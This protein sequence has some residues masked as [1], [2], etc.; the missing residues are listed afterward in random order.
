MKN[1]ALRNEARMPMNK[2]R[3]EKFDKSGVNQIAVGARTAGNDVYAIEPSASAT[4]PSGFHQS[5]RLNSKG[6]M[7]D[8]RPGK[9]SKPDGFLAHKMVPS[10]AHMT[11][12]HGNQPH[13]QNRISKDLQPILENEN[14]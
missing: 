7:H 9:S 1:T 6:A 3:I 10:R 2:D 8:F 5:Q 4:H 13:N 11:D 14:A 12:I